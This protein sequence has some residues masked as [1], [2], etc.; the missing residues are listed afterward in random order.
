MRITHR[1]RAGLVAAGALALAMLGG[2]L[3]YAATGS[4]SPAQQ[5]NDPDVYA[6]VNQA[7]GIDYLE[8]RLPIPHACW[9]ASET[10]W[11]LDPGGQVTPGPTVT[12]TSG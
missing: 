3:A 4:S 9:F 2:G 7:G 10:L 8:Y 11:R 1:R 12:A 5:L 6:C